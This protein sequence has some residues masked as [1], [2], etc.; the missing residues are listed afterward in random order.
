MLVAEHAI[1]SSWTIQYYH[2]NSSA[3]IVINQVQC[4]MKTEAA[5][6]IMYD[7]NFIILQ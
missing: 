1:P 6:T 2:I 4:L 3:T 5:F 7:R